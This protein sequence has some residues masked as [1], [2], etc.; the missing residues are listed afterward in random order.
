MKKTFLYKGSPN[1]M[2]T[3]TIQSDWSRLSGSYK[4]THLIRTGKSKLD[5]EFN[6]IRSQTYF[7]EHFQGWIIL[8]RFWKDSI[9]A[10][11]QVNN[12][13]SYSRFWFCLFWACRRISTVYPSVK[14]FSEKF[15]WFTDLI[16][17][18][19]YNDVDLK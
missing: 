12:K 17:I 2:H 15:R 3:V 9:Q 19:L 4:N 18:Q 10:L 5:P 16:S 8:F 6:Y 13:R 11:Y 14:H 1:I 7:F